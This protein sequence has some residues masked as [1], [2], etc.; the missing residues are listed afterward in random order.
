V[1]SGID[2]FSWLEDGEH[3]FK[4]NA[5]AGYVQAL[6]AVLEDPA[7]TRDRVAAAHDLAVGLHDFR[8]IGEKLERLYRGAIAIRD[9]MVR[10]RGHV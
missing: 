8:L 4:A 1:C 5:V 9:A 3:C 2:A 7:A 6:R 10:R